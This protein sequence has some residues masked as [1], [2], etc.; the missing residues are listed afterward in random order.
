MTPVVAERLA[1]PRSVP[2]AT[3]LPTLEA[4]T[5][6]IAVPVFSGFPGRL[7]VLTFDTVGIHL[8]GKKPF[9]A[10]WTA[11]TQLD[12]R[13]GQVRLRTK[14]R[15]LVLTVAVDRVA[16]PTLGGQ[17]VR[18]LAEARRGSLDRSGSALLEFRNASDRL[19][20]EFQDEDDLFTPAVIGVVLAATA[21]ACV[22]MAPHML[23]LGAS[24]AVLNGIFVI[25]SRIS[26]FDPRSLLTGLA[27]AAMLASLIVRVASKGQAVVWARGTLRGWHR[28]RPVPTLARLVLATVVARPAIAAA[29]LLLGATLALPSARTLVVVDGSGL[30]VVRELPFLD[31]E[32]SWKAVAEIT[33]VPAPL[34]RHPS[35][36]AVVVRFA[37]GASITTLGHYLRGGTDKQF[38]DVARTWRDAA[39]ERGGR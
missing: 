23:A 11:V 9:G 10:P 4:R 33:S 15:A 17:L 7:G 39:T 12:V 1:R 32:R 30:K 38:L 31:E 24:P 3:P 5:N 34:D 27:A 35:G 14:E 2:A 16:E 28:G 25:D 13:R 37:D 36:V 8:T 29:V 26:L 22:A 19:R 18:L 20:D 6:G 21:V